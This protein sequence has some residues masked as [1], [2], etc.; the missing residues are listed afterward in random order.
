M[1]VDPPEVSKA[2]Q[3]R[4]KVRFTFLS[5]P[6]AELLERLDIVHRDSPMRGDIA[7]PTAVLVDGAGVVRWTYESD[8]YRTRAD[9]EQ[10]MAVIRELTG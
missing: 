10:V 4:L 7:Y 2:L 5:D 3:E 1:S 9:P 6:H 8:T